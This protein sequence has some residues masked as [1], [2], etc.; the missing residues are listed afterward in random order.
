MSKK[1]LREFMQVCYDNDNTCIDAVYLLTDEVWLKS[2]GWKQV[3]HEGIG[4]GIYSPNENIVA[5]FDI[6][7]VPSFHSYQLYKYNEKAWKSCDGDGWD[8]IYN[9]D[10]GEDYDVEPINK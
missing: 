5:V 3:F 9:G 8:R 6:D 2:M 1:T 4:D 7:D 10:N